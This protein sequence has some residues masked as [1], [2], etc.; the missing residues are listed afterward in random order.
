M[1]FYLGQS[2]DS[3]GRMIDEIHDWDDDNLEY[4]H[5]YIQWLFPLAERSNF[6]PDAPVLDS[7]Q[8]QAFRADGRLRAK[9]IESFKLMLSFYGLQCDGA[10]ET[11]KVS[12]SA[13]Y[14]ERKR[15]WLNKGNHNYLRITRILTSVRVLG[16]E[17]Y[18]QALFD[19]LDQLYRE[20][21]GRIGHITYAY[22]KRAVGTKG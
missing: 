21:S 2:P 13:E 22:W 16:L 6:N 8:I 15:I 19:F 17:E 7:P 9:L 5:D 4:I 12:K 3:S 14:L 10:D 18:A 1:S 11:I 20:E